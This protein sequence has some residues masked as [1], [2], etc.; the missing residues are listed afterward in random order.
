MADTNQA[1]QKNSGAGKF[2]YKVFSVF[3]RR[4]FQKIFAI[5]LKIVP[6]RKPELVEGAGK[7]KE[8]PKF[9]KEKGKQKP[10]I[11]TDKT[12]VSLG[13][14]NGFLE[15]LQAENMP[16][17]VFDGVVP[18][19]TIDNIE[20]GLKIYLAEGCD[21][22]VPFGGGSAMDCAKIIG[23]RVKKPNKP[24]QKMKGYF[25]ILKKLPRIFAV[26]T[27]A[28]T[29]SEATVAAVIKDEKTHDKYPINDLCLVPHYAVLDPELTVG[30]PPH[31]TSTTGMDT[32]T[33][34]VE[35]YIG[36]S[37]TSLTFEMA[38]RAVKLTFDNLKVAY[39]E[40]TNIEARGNM[41]RAAY[42]GGVAFT[43]G[44]IGYVHA[45]AHAI[46][47]LYGTPHGLANAVILPY[48]LEWF[49]KSAHE[50]LANLAELTEV[51]DYSDTEAVKAEKFIAAVR[52]YNAYMNI[53]EKLRIKEED[54]AVI[55]ERAMAESKWMYPVPRIM[56]KNEMMELLAQIAE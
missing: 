42:Y 39:D 14:L 52:A 44:F 30:L 23:A 3:P 26:P 25:K 32:L 12:L 29:G 24:V 37:N 10:L 38:V 18:N 13:L 36:R 48:V 56:R 20:D 7:I 33:H 43:R 55:T 9:I 28:G 21:C 31:I 51:C 8:L 35:S 53:P 41:Q 17:A 22:L 46:G 47:G 49:G 6:I 45:I 4:V 27:T 16:Y 15:G 2:A 54:F 11:V 19:P 1:T 34:A 5:A 40:P 50:R